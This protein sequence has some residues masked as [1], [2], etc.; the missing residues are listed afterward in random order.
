M[1]LTRPASGLL[2]KAAP[3]CQMFF[4]RGMALSG[5]KGFAEHEKT[6]ED[7]YFTKEDQ[8]QA[9]LMR[10]GSVSQQRGERVLS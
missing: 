4:S 3:A 7:M 2:T 8:V 9:E 5:V 6:V 10:A 1:A